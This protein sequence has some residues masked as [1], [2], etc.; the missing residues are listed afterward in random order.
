[1]MRFVCGVFCI[2]LSFGFWALPAAADSP[3]VTDVWYY[4]SGW[5]SADGITYKGT[6]GRNCLEYW[7]EFASCGD[8]PNDDGTGVMIALEDGSSGAAFYDA[9]M[10]FDSDFVD[11]LEDYYNLGYEWL[12]WTTT[13]GTINW[14]NGQK[15]AFLSLG[16]TKVYTTRVYFRTVPCK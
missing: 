6:C 5:V 3:V 14:S 4:D 13:S 1:M 12:I 7:A 10:Y 9:E 8:L 11:E 15:I 2:L 16:T